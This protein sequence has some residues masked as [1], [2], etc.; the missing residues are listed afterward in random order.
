[1][2]LII[3]SGGLSV[4]VSLLGTPLLISRL[5]RRGYAQAIRQSTAEINYPAH[6]SK[7]GTPSMGGLA[8]ILAILVGYLGTHAVFWSAPS[9]SGLLALWLI[10]GLAAVGLADDY[11]K[12]F[13]RRST[14]VRARTKLIGQAFVAVTFALLSVQFPDANGITPASQAISFVKDTPLVLPVAIFVLWVWF[15]VTSTTNG[16]N[17]TDGLDGL[18]TG[19]ALASF[20]TYIVITGWQFGQ[21]CGRSPVEACFE[22]RD[23]LDLTVLAS[24]CAGACFGFLWWNTHPAR[25]FMGD[26]GSLALG[27]G[28]AALA[29]LSR[30]ELLLLLVG[31]LF[32]LVTA[33]VIL[34][35]ASFKLTR[36]RIFRMAPLHHHFELK[37]W[38]ESLIVVRFWIIQGLF[39]GAAVTVFFAEWVV[40]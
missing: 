17:L 38:P 8:M 9:A 24:A 23:P 30:T 11:L 1:M 6:D 13:K 12:I 3:L 29:I 36:R 34:Q 4:L 33:S 31:G 15:L 19:A 35:V 26:T 25:I 14:G 40:L 10:L 21:S 2:T 7:Q 27:G 37:G 5:R 32:V 16:V 18:A 28:I 39:I 22:V 20:V